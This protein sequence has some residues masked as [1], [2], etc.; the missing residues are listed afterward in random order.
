MV[1]GS[2]EPWMRYIGAAEIHGPGAERVL[3]AARHVA[4]QVGPTLQH[5]GRRR[6]VRPFALGRDRLGAATI[7]SRAGRRRRRSGAPDGRAA[8]NRVAALPSRSRWCRANR[9]RRRPRSRAER[10]SR[11]AEFRSRLPAGR[12]IGRLADRMPSAPRQEARCWRRAGRRDRLVGR[13]QKERP[14]IG[15]CRGAAASRKPA[16]PRRAPDL[17]DASNAFRSTTIGRIDRIHDVIPLPY[18]Y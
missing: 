6:P 3:D 8:R 16:R 15:A 18:E 17:F 11:A 4:R 1:S 2:F 14:F 10:A 9:G 12:H 7:R 5:L 13:I